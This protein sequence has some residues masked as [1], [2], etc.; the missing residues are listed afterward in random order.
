MKKALPLLGAASRFIAGVVLFL[1]L[2]ACTGSTTSKVKTDDMP[3][4]YPAGLIE[5]NLNDAAFALHI[6]VK[7]VRIDEAK[8]LRSG[9]G[10]IGYAALLF[11]GEV[12]EVYKGD[13]TPGGG[14][15]FVSFW[16]Y[17]D[18]LLE[19]QRKENRHR[20]VF[21]NKSQSGPYLALGFGI[22][23][24]DEELDGS[25]RRNVRTGG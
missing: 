25:I 2:T 17:F 3:G 5:A 21:L 10:K 7:D 9:N 12:V 16:E 18:G 22:F 24:F 20:I 11:D 15:S 1:S 13:L 23:V 4:R 14:I 6:V 8:S 19:E